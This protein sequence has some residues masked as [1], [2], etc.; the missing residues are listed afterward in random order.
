MR[1]QRSEESSGQH[2]RRK[3][4]D[5]HK[6]STRQTGPGLA[7]NRFALN[8][9]FLGLRSMYVL[10]SVYCVTVTI[11]LRRR[12]DWAA[13]GQTMRSKGWVVWPSGTQS[14]RAFR[15]IL[16]VPHRLLTGDADFEDMKTQTRNRLTLTTLSFLALSSTLFGGPVQATGRGDAKDAAKSNR[17]ATKEQA[18]T[19][20]DAAKEKNKGLREQTK[21]EN[22]ARHDAAVAKCKA[23]LIAAKAAGT[24]V[25]AA[26]EA[27]RLA[28]AQTR[29]ANR[30]AREAT[31]LANAAT[32]EA[33][34]T[35]NEALRKSTKEANERARVEARTS[36]KAAGPS[37]APGTPA[38]TVAS[39]PKSIATTTP[40]PVAV[41]PVPA[42]S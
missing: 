15:T 6:Q 22:E 5:E 20:R 17:E 7:T 21:K 25:D 26:R 11:S 42:A 33:T 27:C 1:L 9:P 10:V 18:E 31:E 40:P 41:I 14:Q 34:R 38:T 30:A 32:R 23:D 24:G 28:L 8:A 2:L 39:V 29:E 35:S 37:T 36:A 12:Y 4:A 16:R 3:S 19:A 13:S